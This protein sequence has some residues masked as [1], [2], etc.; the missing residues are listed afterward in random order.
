MQ[1]VHLV[2]I[3]PE[4]DF[5][6]NDDSA[7]PVVG[8]NSD[9]KRVSGLV[10]RIG[11]KLR[12]IHVTL[13]QH[14]NIGIERP[15]FWTNDNGDA[16]A[17]FTM[18]RADDIRSGIWYPRNGHFRPAALGGLTLRQ[19]ALHYAEELEKKGN[20][21]LIIWPVHCP[22][23]SWG[24]AVQEDLF[25]ELRNWEVRNFANVDY[26]TKGS[27]IYTEHYGAVEAEVPLASDPTTGL[28]TSF[29]RMLQD[30][31]IIAIAG[32]ASSHCVKSTVNQ[33]AGKF[34]DDLLGKFWLLTDCMSPVSQVGNGPDFP[35]IA[36]AWL[37]D[38][39]RRGMHLTDSKSFL[40]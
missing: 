18:I 16:P 40:A 33:I 31:D 2:V 3:D 9:M 19:Y 26:V 24:A 22:I 21:P 36:D 13:D 32:E 5:M 23:G 35:A 12:D 28:N 11:P 15:P 34:G 10:K 17:P 4:N 7:L 25:G 14:R 20:Y 27:C 38:M 6:D 39:E 1:D 8:A 37:K 30:A 29:L